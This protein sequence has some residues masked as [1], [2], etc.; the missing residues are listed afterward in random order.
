MGNRTKT[1]RPKKSSKPYVGF[2]LTAHKN[3]TWV[4]K[5]KGRQYYF[6][7]LDDW[8]AA[9]ARFE[10]E[11]THIISGRKIPPEDAGE[12]LRRRHAE[13]RD[14]PMS[15]GVQVRV[16]QPA[17]RTRG[18]LRPIVQSFNRSSAKTLRSARNE[19]GPR[20]FEAVEIRAIFDALDGKPV[21]VAG[22]DKPVKLKADP[23]MK[24]MVMLAANTGFGNN[25]VARLPLSA[26]DLEAGWVVFA[27]P[28]TGIRRRIPLWTETIADP[29]GIGGSPSQLASR[30]R[31]GIMRKSRSKKNDSSCT[32]N[33]NT[34]S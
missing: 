33:E 17:D 15:D 24:A 13:G 29:L 7:P 20:M 25:D 12:P 9:L 32:K 22:K 27:R 6:G 34:K 28:K 21:S 31:H 5:H 30:Q 2:S 10:H 19:A 23:V 14:Q 1:K 26:L 18:E 16:R 8:P 11:W 4:E 3:G